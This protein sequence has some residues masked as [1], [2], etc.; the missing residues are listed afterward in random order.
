MKKIFSI[1]LMLM[2][3]FMMIG[4]GKT[5]NIEGNLEDLMTKIYD[6]ISENELPMM[7]DNI[8]LTDENKVSFIGDADITYKEAIASESMVGSIAHSVVLIRMNEEAT[9]EEINDAM[10][11]LKDNINPRKWICVGVEEVQVE[12]NGNLIIV[13]LNDNYGDKLIANFKNIK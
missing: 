4:C 5:V 8:E 3:C 11:K 7:L 2:C 10:K 12:S 1:G 13:V 6:G 9:Q